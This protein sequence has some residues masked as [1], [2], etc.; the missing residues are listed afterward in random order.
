MHCLAIAYFISK[1]YLQSI[2]VGGYLFPRVPK[3][4]DLLD[5]LINNF[6]PH[7]SLLLLLDLQGKIIRTS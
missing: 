4:S 6:T 3:K 1:R 2:S 5:T 7:S